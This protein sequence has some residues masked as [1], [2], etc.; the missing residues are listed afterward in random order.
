MQRAR[1]ARLELAAKRDLVPAAA[2]HDQAQPR[3]GF[4]LQVAELGQDE[5]R[6]TKPVPEP[7]LRLARLKGQTAE[8]ARRGRARVAAAGIEL[9]PD[10]FGSSLNDLKAIAALCLER[11]GCAQ[12][13]GFLIGGRRPKQRAASALCA[14]QALARNA[15]HRPSERYP[16]SR[17]VEPGQIPCDSLDQLA[18][19]EH[20]VSD[21]NARG[22]DRELLA[23][24]CLL[25]SATY[26]WQT[27][28]VNGC[29]PSTFRFEL[30]ISSANSAAGG[31]AAIERCR[32]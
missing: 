24:V 3:A 15:G 17:A 10:L 30:R 29:T 6:V 4:V 12:A 2:A 32:Y 22:S 27:P 26:R 1:Q 28:K 23:H 11:E 19:V 8:E 20:A 14:E 13:A 16:R 18:A 5:A 7:A 9:W 31:N 21:A 25:G